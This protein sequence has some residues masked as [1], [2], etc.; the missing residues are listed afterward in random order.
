MENTQNGGSFVATCQ[1]TPYLPRSSL[2]PYMGAGY[3]HFATRYERTC[4]V[5]GP[6][7]VAPACVYGRGGRLR[8]CP[9]LDFFTPS[10]G[11]ILPFVDVFILYGLGKKMGWAMGFFLEDMNIHKFL[12][13]W[14][15]L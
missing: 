8:G 9:E 10:G 1:E 11:E 14:S 15:T 4:G 12:L 6:F 7:K 2:D 13:S 3:W 5:P